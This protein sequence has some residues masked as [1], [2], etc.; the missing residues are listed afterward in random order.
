V[1]A[2]AGGVTS[3]A[4]ATTRA[5]G[6]SPEQTTA[7]EASGDILTGLGWGLLAL[8]LL[9][10]AVGFLYWR[11][12]RGTGEPSPAAAATGGDPDADAAGAGETVVTDEERVLSHLEASG[13]RVRQGEIAEALD[14]SASKTSRVLGRMA[15]DGSVVKR[16]LG[17]E[18]LVELP[19]E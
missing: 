5:T 14:W 18:N 12:R 1:A 6:E 13:G 10:G 3:R 15:E 17:R 8:L 7:T 19:E 16:R 11:R 2:T 9:V 4:P